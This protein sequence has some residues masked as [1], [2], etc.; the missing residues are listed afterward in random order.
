MKKTAIILSLIALTFAITGCAS[1]TGNT[2]ATEKTATATTTTTASTLPFGI[3][4][5][6]YANLLETSVFD[7]GNNNRVKKVLENLR[8]GKDV[9]IAML[10]G[11]ITEGV[12]PAN[13]KMGY[14][15]R[16]GDMV[17]ETYTPDKGAHVH[18]TDAGLSGTPSMLGLIR[19]QKDVVDQLG[20]TPDLL[21]L[22][23]AVNDSGDSSMTR[24]YEALVRTALTQN[25]ETAIIMLFSENGWTAQAQES[26]VGYYYELP[27]VSVK[28]AYDDAV[29][30][31]LITK[32]KFFADYVHPTKDGHQL[33]ADC[34]MHLLSIVD[35]AAADEHKD[36]PG[37][38][39]NPPEFTG[40]QMVSSKTTSADYTI[41]AGTFTAKDTNAQAFMNSNKIAFPDNFYHTAGTDGGSFKMTITCKNLLFVYKTNG[42]WDNVTF[43]KAEVYVDG[44]LFNTYDG[45]A[46]S[47]WNNP[48]T[49]VLVDAENAGKHTVEVKMASGDEKKA[50]T[51]YAFG[52]TK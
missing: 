2:T 12:G 49:V 3:S 15:Y 30:N 9:Y 44:K 34:L 16:F 11:S 35:K 8:A 21:V 23:F 37:D 36:M 18:F 39:L 32:A 14:A 6:D 52:Y 27:M 26:D 50:F 47:G 19:Y 13:Y 42:K 10:G 22:E 43:G 29:S 46:S 48:V 38:A 1:T 33:M 4:S 5:T 17:K 51:V 25:P 31:G 20:H 41:D 7:K 24:T 28:D 45:G 40:A